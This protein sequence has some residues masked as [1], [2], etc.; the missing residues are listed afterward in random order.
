[1]RR[2]RPGWRSVALSALLASP[3]LLLS[4]PASGSGPDEDGPMT[5]VAGIGL[6][7]PG[8]GAR[9]TPI[10]HLVRPGSERRTGRMVASGT[11]ST[12]RDP[13]APVVI[14]P[15][16]FDGV[17]NL[18]PLATPGDPTGALGITNHVAAVNVH[19]AA[20]S[21]AGVELYE[22]KR[23]RSLDEQLPSGAEDFDPKVVY[24]PYDQ[25]FMVVF[26]AATGQQSFMSIVVIPEGAEDDDTQAG[27]CTLHMSGDQMIGNG[28]QFADYPML[29]FTSNRVTLTTNQ[30]DFT[31]APEIGRFRYVQIVSIRKAD[32][33]DCAVNPVPIEVFGGKKTQDPDGSRAFT[34]VPAI[35]TGGDPR[36]Q[37]MA[38]LDFNGSTGKLILWRLR[39]VHGALKLSRAQVASGPMA[40]PPFGFQCGGTARN[41]DTWWDPGDARLTSAFWDEDLGRLYTATS[42]EGNKGGGPVESIVKWWEV[43]PA[44]TLAA[45]DVVRK[46][47]VGLAGRDSGWPSVA[48]DGDGN[49]WLTYARAGIAGVDECL[50]AYAAVVPPASVSASEVLIRAGEARYQAQGGPERWGDYTALTRDPVTATTVSAYGAYALDDGVGATDL[51]QQTIATLEDV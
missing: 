34:V 37:H 41:A 6:D 8:G 36:T 25:V 1:M 21:R 17:P 28:K 26:L 43:D 49:L 31:D 35:S 24:D 9:E 33:Y 47:T 39:F 3:S 22:P 29:G 13:L 10:P 44:S 4:S 15:G 12:S 20:Y 48:T 45:S 18:P 11:G 7:A 40:L 30:F 5:H 46:G 50:S 14:P 32:L 19:M 42:V 23:L 2:R 16:A 51:W 38:S 27:W